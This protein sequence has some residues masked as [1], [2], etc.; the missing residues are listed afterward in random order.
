MM[1]FNSSTFSLVL[2]IGCQRFLAGF[3]TFL[4]SLDIASQPSFS[5]FI[6]FSTFFAKPG[7]PSMVLPALQRQQLRRNNLLSALRH[8]GPFRKQPRL[9][10]GLFGFLI[11]LILHLASGESFVAA[12]MSRRRI[13]RIAVMAA[14]IA[15]W[16]AF[17]SASGGFASAD[18]HQ[19][20]AKNH[21]Y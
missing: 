6:F 8:W 16:A 7:G 17:R 9:R 18:E 10:I 19:G 12:S 14:S 2:A 15:V 21:H 3:Q 11:F 13:C 5:S 20:S 4:E 1:A